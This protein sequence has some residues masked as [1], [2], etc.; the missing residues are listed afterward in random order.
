MK[1]RDFPR[2]TVFALFIGAGAYI[3]ACA[4][5]VAGLALPGV[6]LASALGAFLLSLMSSPAPSNFEPD[7]RHARP[8]H[9]GSN[10]APH[11]PHA[12]DYL[13]DDEPNW[14]EE[15]FKPNSLTS[16]TR[17]YFEI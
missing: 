10:S 12:S 2:A 17:D 16:T 1:N 14:A 6:V 11:S 5:H 7:Y 9:D 4:W 15:H 3:A 8:V 13:W